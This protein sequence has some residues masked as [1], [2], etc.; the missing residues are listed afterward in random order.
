MLDLPGDGLLG[1]LRT[2]RSGESLAVLANLTNQ[3]RMIS[4]SSV[5]PE[6][7]YDELSEQRIYSGEDIP[8]RP[9]QV[10]WLTAN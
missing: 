9:F 7:G 8:M 1:L 6:L 3:P 4:R 10:R 5:D 2:A